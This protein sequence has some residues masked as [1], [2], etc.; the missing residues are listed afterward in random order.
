MF[1]HIM[2]ILITEEQHNMIMENVMNEPIIYVEK[3]ER[4]IFLAKNQFYVWLYDDPEAEKKLMGREYDAVFFPPSGPMRVGGYN[5][6]SKIWNKGY[7]KKSKGAEHLMGIIKG[8]Y[9]EDENKVVIDMMTVRPNAR[10]RGINS[11]MIQ[12]IRQ[13][14]G[15]SQNDIIFDD[16][17][18][19]GK[20][21]ADSKKY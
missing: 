4:A 14:F 8:E 16:P 13:E 6:L 1:G 11:Y 18:E 15:V 7:L 2:K 5:L 21:F 17:T 3:S 12:K 9:L 10:R 19:M 20:K